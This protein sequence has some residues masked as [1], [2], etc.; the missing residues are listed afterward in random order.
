MARKPKQAPIEVKT[1]ELEKEFTVIK[2]L[3]GNINNKSYSAEVGEKVMFN[4]FEA[5]VF[6]NL[7]K[8]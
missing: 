6:K 3:R 5:S 4:E 7:I 2:K 1:P 8:E